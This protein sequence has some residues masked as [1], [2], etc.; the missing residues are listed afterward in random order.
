MS[1]TYAIP[2]VTAS[3]S[4]LLKQVASVTVLR[5]SQIADGEPTLNIFLYHV[6]P[7][8]ALRNADLPFRNGSGALVGQPTVALNLSYLLTPVGETPHEELHAQEI[9]AHA[10]SVLHD[11]AVLGREQIRKAVAAFADHPDLKKSDL[12]DQVESV[13]LTPVPLSS[14]DHHRLWSMFAA[15]YRLSVAYEAT[16]VLISRPQETK[17]ALPV[18]M[19]LVAAVPTRRPR[20][21]ALRPPIVATGEKLT[22]EGRELAGDVVKVLFETGEINPDRATDRAIEVVPPAGLLAGIQTV[23]VVQRIPLGRPP[24]LHRGFESNVAAFMRAPKIATDPPYAVTLGTVATPADG[25]LEL[26]LEPPVG[27]SQQVRLVVGERTYER[28]PPKLDD[29][30]RTAKVAFTIPKDQPLGRHLLRVSVDGAE[31]VLIVD[32]TPGSPTFDEYVAPVVE[33]KRA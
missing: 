5:P 18:R 7:N 14:E 11:N 10:V 25:T 12:A 27:R 24:T 30:D 23:R 33:V 6:A 16:V 22:I 8:P 32:A 9:L 20:I 15:S 28:V 3:L 31:S 2:A 17:A 21:D 13:K 19:P 26:D 1:N 29:P 4:E